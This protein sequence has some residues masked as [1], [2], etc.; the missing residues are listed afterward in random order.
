[1]AELV[2]APASGAG[3]GNGVEVRVLFWAPILCSG[4]SRN[5][6]KAP[7]KRGFLLGF[8]GFTSL[9]VHRRVVA[10]TISD[11]IIDGIAAPCHHAFESDA[12]TCHSLRPGFARSNRATSLPSTETW[13]PVARR[14]SER[15]QALANGL[16][17]RGQTA[18]ARVWCLSGCL[19]RP[20]ACSSGWRE[21]AARQGCRS[22]PEEKQDKIARADAREE[23]QLA[24]AIH[25]L[26]NVN[27]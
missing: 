3:T 19:A 16:S 18:A 7:R 15:Q 20:G 21:K 8:A 24:R 17:P 27:T 1:M 23:P 5:I 25:L 22:I 9:T 11:G 10:S 4:S 6:Q 2:D 14:Q 12:I 13:R 26:P